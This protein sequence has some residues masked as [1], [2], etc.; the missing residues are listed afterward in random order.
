VI[1]EFTPQGQLPDGIHIA[2]GS[3]LLERFLFNEYRKGFWGPLV[4]IF[5]WAKYKYAAAVFVGGSFV[6]NTETPHDIDCLV[7]FPHEDSIPH[8]SEL[9]TI[10]STRLDLQFC[11]KSD[12][13]VLGSYLQLFSRNRGR[14]PVGV[15]QVD[16]YGEGKA[17]EIIFS[18]E[19]ND[20]EII[21]RAYINRHYV[22]HYDPNG[23]LVSIHG[24]LSDA[25]WNAEI[26]PIASS[27][28]WVFAPFLYNDINK[29]GLLIDKAKT[30]EVI[31]RFRN[32]IYDIQSR[33]PYNISVIAHSFGTYILA[34]Y[35]SGFGDFLPIR[36]NAAILTGSIIN[37]DLDW[38]SHR[39]IR[40]SR[41]LNE[42]APN[43]QWV[44]HMPKLKWIYSDSLY[45]N[46][47]VVGFNKPNDILT[48]SSNEIFDH[49][50]VIKRDVI[51]RHWM[52]FL[53]ANRHAYNIEG[54][55]YIL[56]K[57]KK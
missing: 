48:Q 51:E 49:N 12:E 37:S 15:V 28:N 35:I 30:K 20:Y 25:S 23:V 52:P 50:N 39:G 45:G 7:V 3:E 55:R 17:W 43:D 8:K 44:R 1:P 56:Q 10:E 32:W 33:Y 19:A 41:I 31:E 13:K 16:L 46:S 57:Y 53:M 34:K 6:T 47:G 29:P 4:N 18:S 24:L 36:L 2:S 38:G 26:A 54:E 22:D 11:A 42:I 14:E 40:I 9:L 27:Q 21:K 5:D